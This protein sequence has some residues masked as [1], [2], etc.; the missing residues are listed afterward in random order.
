M[1]TFDIWDWETCDQIIYYNLLGEIINNGD[2][3]D[4]NNINNNDNNSGNDN[5]INNGN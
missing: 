4:N 3:N 1:T 2:N 5:I